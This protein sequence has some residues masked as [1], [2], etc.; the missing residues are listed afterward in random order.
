MK[1]TLKVGHDGMM[2]TPGSLAS[3]LA[4]RRANTDANCKEFEA[5]MKTNQER[6]EVSQEELEATDFEA[7]QE[8]IDSRTRA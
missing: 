4:A 1:A 2:T 3:R 7:N 5:I 6:M 8:E